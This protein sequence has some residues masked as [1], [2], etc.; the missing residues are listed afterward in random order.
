[1]QAFMQSCPR[2]SSENDADN[3][4]K[5]PVLYHCMLFLLLILGSSLLR[6]HLS[7]M[8][9]RLAYQ[10]LHFSLPIEHR[11]SHSETYSLMLNQELPELPFI[12]C[13]LENIELCISCSGKFPPQESISSHSPWPTGI[14]ATYQQDCSGVGLASLS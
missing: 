1:M 14:M 6:N 3:S 8:N 2:N 5:K 10:L 13:C 9:L 7:S 11:S 12:S 4:N